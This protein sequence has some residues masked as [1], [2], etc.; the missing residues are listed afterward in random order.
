MRQENGNYLLTGIM[1]L[2]RYFARVEISMSDDEFYGAVNFSVPVGLVPWRDPGEYVH[3][4][5]G[6]ALTR[7]EW[8]DLSRSRSPTS[9]RWLG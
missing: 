8:L 7:M 4:V 1:W 5:T 9:R 3:T 6:K 2:V